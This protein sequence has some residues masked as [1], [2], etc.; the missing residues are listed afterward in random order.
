MKKVKRYN[1]VALINIDATNMEEAEARFDRI[2]SLS[3]EGQ[4]TFLRELNAGIE[5]VG[6]DCEEVDT[7]FESK[8]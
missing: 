6:D 7:T 3:L 2:N 1:M 5:I 8:K 4:L